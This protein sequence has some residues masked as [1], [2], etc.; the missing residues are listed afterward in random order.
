MITIADHISTVNEIIEMLVAS[1]HHADPGSA[2]EER[3]SKSLEKMEAVRG[4]LDE[5]AE[6]LSP[7]PGDLGDLSDIPSELRRELSVV[8]VDDLERKLV[9]V[10]QAYGGTASLDQI[11]VGLFRK[12]KEVQKRRFVQNKLYRMSGKKLIYTVPK[13]R[14]LYTINEPADR[15]S[16]GKQSDWGEEPDDEIPF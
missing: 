9:Q 1:L 16:E 13:R 11:L 14:G 3:L 7:L 5:Q 15:E 6:I 12:F 4:F 10:V 8:D 2:R